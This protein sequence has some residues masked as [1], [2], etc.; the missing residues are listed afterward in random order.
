M[1]KRQCFTV[2]LICLQCHDHCVTHCRVSVCCKE[3]GG[4]DPDAHRSCW[5][6]QKLYHR[7]G[8]E[9]W[10]GV[11]YNVSALFKMSFCVNLLH[12][13]TFL[14]FCHYCHFTWKLGQQRESTDSRLTPDAVHLIDITTDNDPFLHCSGGYTGRRWKGANTGEMSH[15]GSQR[16]IKLCLTSAGSVAPL[17]PLCAPGKM[18]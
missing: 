11:R 8:D 5:E 1:E 10:E 12:L 18:I 16:G 6:K 7:S 13:A 17:C 15:Q 2:Q 3:L 9:W 14:T 4:L